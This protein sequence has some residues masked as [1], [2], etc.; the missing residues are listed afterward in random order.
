MVAEEVFLVATDVA[1]EKEIS[2]VAW[3]GVSDGMNQLGDVGGLG[4][5]CSRVCVLE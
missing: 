2:S 5:G 3:Y 4:T 1:T